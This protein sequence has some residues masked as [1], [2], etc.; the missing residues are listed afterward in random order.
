MRIVF[1]LLLAL[2]LSADD[3]VESQKF[4]QAALNAEKE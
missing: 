1:A 2:S 3:V 4:Y